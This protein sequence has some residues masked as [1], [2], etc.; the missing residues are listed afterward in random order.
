LS[1]INE[2]IVTSLIIVSIVVASM[3]MV[4]SAVTPL[5]TIFEN[6]RLKMTAEK[7][8]TQILLSPGDPVDWGGNPNIEDSGLRVFGLASRYET[9]REAYDLDVDKVGRLDESN[10][11]YLSPQRALGLLNLDN[12][13]GFILEIIPM[14]IIDASWWLGSDGLNVYVRVKNPEG[15]NVVGAKVAAKF[16]WADLGGLKESNPTPVHSQSIYETDETGSCAFLFP[17]IQDIPPSGVI[18]I[19]V[20]NHGSRNTKAIP[21]LAGS[22]TRTLRP[23]A[24]GDYQ[25]WSSF[26]PHYDATNDKNDKT[27]ISASKNNP[28]EKGYIID[29]EKFEDI[30]KFYIQS[31]TA[32]ARCM[33]IDTQ[34]QKKI[35]I[36]WR[37]YSQNYF[38][39][40]FNLKIGVWENYTETLSNNPVT[41]RS[42]T[43]EEICDLQIGVG[44]KK[45][46]LTQNEKVLCSELWLEVKYMGMTAPAYISGRTFFVDKDLT[47]L[48]SSKANVREVLPIVRNGEITFREVD[49]PLSS[50]G[51]VIGE[52]AE[53]E[54]SN[55]ESSAVLFLAAFRK[56]SMPYTV[57]ASREIELYGIKAYRTISSIYT[58][59]GEK[60]FPLS[61]YVERT[62]KIGGCTYIARM[63]IWRMSY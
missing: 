8:L 28:S 52:K 2:Y 55:M 46:D 17:N 34:E 56:G 33:A 29:T 21:V 23:N 7:L 45:G 36:I 35:S 31:I 39:S 22:W 12:E 54:I 13:Y 44:V 1:P 37:T 58:G 63:Y 60:E 47:P 18:L 30:E 26:Q 19:Y 40:P 42:W 24:P 62:V 50:T 49:F 25:H 9:T 43:W 27:Y 32:Y 10:P 5:R 4:I 61:A 59:V 53:Y 51:K 57:Y 20:D 41:K 3:T 38:S 48:D 14:T 15:Q 11:L 16:F 6:D